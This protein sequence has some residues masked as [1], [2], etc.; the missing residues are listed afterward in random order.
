MEVLHKKRI[1]VP[2][3]GQGSVIHIIRTGIID[4]LSEFA[5]PVVAMLWQQPDLE[6]EL[7]LKG[8]E[9]TVIPTY[10]VSASYSSLRYKINLWYLSY[11]LKTPGVAIEAALHSTYGKKKTRKAFFIKKLR[12]LYNS[13]LFAINP[14]YIESLLENEKTAIEREEI[15]QEYNAWIKTLNIDGMFTVTPFLYEVDLMARI[16]KADDKKIIASIHSFDNVTKRGWQSTVFD[17]YIV[18]NKYNQAE[19]L[20]IHDRQLQKNVVH[21]A[22]APQFDFHYNPNYSWSKE[23]WSIRMNIPQGKKVI[24]YAGGA[25]TLFPTEPQYAKHLK[26]AMEEEDIKNSVILVRCHPLDTI[27]RW[28]NYIGD[29]PFVIYDEPR[30]GQKNLD[31]TNVTDEDLARLVSTLY[32]ADVHINLC[33]TMTVD[34]S[35]FNKPQIA[36]YYDDDNKEGEAA[37][38][39][40]YLQEHYQPILKSNVINK[41]ASKRDL[42]DL[43]KSTLKTP[44]NYTMNCGVCV[45][46]IITYKDGRSAKR[47]STILKRF[48]A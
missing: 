26:E 31:Q 47:V 45:E 25:A 23:E 5:T 4:R 19:L 27:Q 16:L 2:I 22:G 18:W 40:I 21:I 44:S 24:L 8:Y 46:E 35:V 48:F 9:V 34:G 43:V 39:N 28:R 14:N 7:N 41:S 10:K 1:L 15:Y 30:H 3:V 20:R 33:S 42:I 11:K 12:S 17:E 38:R 29:S 37:L 32:H 13:F 36:P 6:K